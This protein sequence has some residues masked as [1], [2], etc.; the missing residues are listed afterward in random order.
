MGIMKRGIRAVLVFLVLLA[1]LVA[2]AQSE[3]PATPAR[4]LVV[5]ETK[6]FL[7]TM[8]IGGLVGAL[9]GSGL[10]QVDVEFASTESDW[11]DPLAEKTPPVDL[12]PY[13]IILVVPRGIDD[14]SSD[15]IWVVSM[16]A[17]SAPAH[18]AAG[19]T[20]AEGIVSL[21]FEGAVDPLGATDDLFVSILYSLYVSEGWMS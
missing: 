17:I 20:M 1:P 16:P 19:L 14:G 13:D 12:E 2:L 7:S 10:F 18:V 3:A 5:D 11:D 21:V 4:L 15:W 9:K 8:R 6:T